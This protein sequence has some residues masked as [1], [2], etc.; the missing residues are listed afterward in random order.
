MKIFRWIVWILM[1]VYMW[2][3]IINNSFKWQ[4][5]ST[6]SALLIFLVS[7]FAVLFLYFYKDILAK[8]W[9]E[10]LSLT[11]HITTKA[12]F[13][14]IFYCVSFLVLVAL[15][16]GNLKKKSNLKFIV[17]ALLLFVWIWIWWL[18]AWINT[19]IIYY[20]VSCYAEEIVKFSTWGNVLQ[21]YEKKDQTSEKKWFW[22]LVLFSILAGLWFSVVEN[23]LYLVVLSTWWEMSIF[24]TLSRSIFTTLLHIVATWIIAFFVI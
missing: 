14:F 23:I 22:N 20:L 21:V 9:L 24:T 11:E 8:I 6:K 12:V 4:K 10:E 19:M 18:L 15:F 13:S 3:W 1:S 5:K 17:V 7:I 16:F 2:I